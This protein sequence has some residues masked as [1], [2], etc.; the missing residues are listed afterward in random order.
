MRRC[1]KLLLLLSTLSPS[2]SAEIAALTRDCTSAANRFSGA[3][4]TPDS[5]YLRLMHRLSEAADSKSGGTTLGWRL[6]PVAEEIVLTGRVWTAD[7]CQAFVPGEGDLYFILT[8][9]EESRD[10]LK[11]FF[12]QKLED[13]PQAVEVELIRDS[14]QSKSVEPFGGWSSCGVRFQDL[15]D[16]EPHCFDVRGYNGR[17]WQHLFEAD[18]FAEVTGALVVDVGEDQENN[19]EVS[20]GRLEVHPAGLIRRLS[21]F[22]GEVACDARLRRR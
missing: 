5:S 3:N 16:A 11:Q 2:L 10:C 1:F 17:D 9:T 8:L 7:E 14:T 21:S 18:G 15:H 12:D 6:Y 19:A 13:V 20:R 4:L 22:D